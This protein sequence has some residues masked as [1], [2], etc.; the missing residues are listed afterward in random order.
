VAL[1]GVEP[2]AR[3]LEVLAT[4]NAAMSRVNGF[5]ARLTPYGLF[6]IVAVAAGTLRPKRSR[7]RVYNVSYVAVSLLVSLW[8]LPGLVAALTPVSASRMCSGGRAT[9][10]SP[11]S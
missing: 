5:V 9:R 2:K 1:I 11:R 3:L 6:A 4:M 8:V 10:S 7:M